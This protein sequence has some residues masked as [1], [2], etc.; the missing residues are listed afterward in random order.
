MLAAGIDEEWVEMNGLGEIVHQTIN[1]T[2]MRISINT[3]KLYMLSAWGKADDYP[4]Q[5]QVEEN[6]SVMLGIINQEQNTESYQIEVKINGI[7]TSILE[8]VVLKHTEKHEQVI[9]FNLDEP[10]DRQKVEFLLFKQGQSEAYRSLYL[11][12]NVK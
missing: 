8:P 1:Q 12:V 5:L 9:T 2:H 7:T 4:T 10:G 3:G 11:W 6:A